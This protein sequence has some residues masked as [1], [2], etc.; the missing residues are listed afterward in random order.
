MMLVATK[1]PHLLNS[2]LLVLLLTDP[3]LIIMFIMDYNNVQYKQT[4]F[5]ALCDTCKSLFST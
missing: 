1:P 2:A 4:L 5:L 3:Q